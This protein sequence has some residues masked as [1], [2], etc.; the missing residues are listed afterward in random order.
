MTRW[1][2][3][4]ALTPDVESLLRAGLASDDLGGPERRALYG[5]GVIA[6]VDQLSATG[7]GPALLA[8]LAEAVRAAGL[9]TVAALPSPA[10]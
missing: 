10:S 3:R 6:A 1:I 5:P 4:E 2:G 7:L 8:R 9:E